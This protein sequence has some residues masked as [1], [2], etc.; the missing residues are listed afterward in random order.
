MQIFNLYI[1]GNN[2]NFIARITVKYND[3][4]KKLALLST[5][6]ENFFFFEK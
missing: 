1:S 6:M 4:L 3:K 2:S 5:N